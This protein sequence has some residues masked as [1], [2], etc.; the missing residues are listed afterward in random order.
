MAVATFLVKN[1]LLWT[2][3]LDFDILIELQEQ[4]H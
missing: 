2:F 1:I 4:S 3:L